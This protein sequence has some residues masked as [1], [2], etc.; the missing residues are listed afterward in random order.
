MK[1]ARSW[2][3]TANQVICDR[4]GLPGVVLVEGEAGIG[5]TRLVT[6]FLATPGGRSGRT[7]AAYCP[8]FRRPHTLGPDAARQAVDTPQGLRLSGLAGALRPLFPEW[9]AVLPPVPEPLAIAR[10]NVGLAAIPWGRY[11]QAA[12][13]LAGSLRLADE[14]LYS[15][16]YP[17]VRDCALVALAQLGWCTG[18]WAGLAGR[19][20]GPAEAGRRAH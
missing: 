6:E 12:E 14:Y 18:N 9:S 10:L 16:L 2:E 11:A 8:A 20:A 15:Y 13:L 17:R 1:R 5:R 7:L 19:R 3:N 4:A